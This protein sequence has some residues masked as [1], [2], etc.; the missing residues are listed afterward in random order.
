MIIPHPSR[1]IQAN[2]SSSSFKA[3]SS[4]FL[5]AVSS[6]RSHSPFPT[7]C[8][9]THCRA[10]VHCLMKWG[11]APRNNPPFSVTISGPLP[12]SCT[13]SPCLSLLNADLSF[14]QPS[15]S[16]L[17]SFLLFSHTYAPILSL[18]APLSL[19]LS[20]RYSTLLLYYS[21]LH[22]HWGIALAW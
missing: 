15:L 19:F 12:L 9:R 18:S 3:P 10:V 5:L 8:D 16:I 1:L 4:R 2:S 7:L 6:S 20:L 21:P 13:V 17:S 22:L 11:A 14:L